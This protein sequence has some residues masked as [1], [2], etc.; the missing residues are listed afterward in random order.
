MFK[1]KCNFE[2]S[3]NEQ[4]YLLSFYSILLFIFVITTYIIKFSIYL[5]VF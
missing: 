2:S 4:M 5:F 3:I 1:N